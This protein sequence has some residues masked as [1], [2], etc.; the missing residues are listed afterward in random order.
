MRSMETQ[1]TIITS[2]RYNHLATNP[3][4]CENCISQI[5][6]V[7]EQVQ[8]LGVSGWGSCTGMRLTTFLAIH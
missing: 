6:F 5:S 7:S 1:S 2:T 4:R 8:I 3:E